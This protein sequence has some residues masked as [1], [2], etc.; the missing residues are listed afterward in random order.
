MRN[1]R[2]QCSVWGFW[3]FG[4]MMVKVRARAMLSPAGD[5]GKPALGRLAERRLHRALRGQVLQ[6]GLELDDVAPVR[7]GGGL[8]H[9]EQVVELLVDE[10]AVALEVVLVDV[11]AGGGAEETLEPGDTHHWQFRSPPSSLAVVCFTAMLSPGSVGN[12][13]AGSR[14]PRTAVHRD[15]SG[16]PGGEHRARDG[17]SKRLPP[18]IPGQARSAAHAGAER[19]AASQARPARPA[20]LRDPEARRQLAALRFPAG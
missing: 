8:P 5:A 2:C 3:S 11:Q 6:D 10:V 4:S 1:A 12:P 16:P 18:G 7:P 9:D 17:R 20:D 15:D 13:P 14:V 19:R